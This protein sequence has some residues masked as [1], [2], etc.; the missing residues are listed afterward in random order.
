MKLTR[1]ELPNWPLCFFFNVVAAFQHGQEMLTIVRELVPG[2]QVSEAEY[3][4]LYCTGA[5]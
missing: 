4:G 2:E 3:M 1:S 5:L